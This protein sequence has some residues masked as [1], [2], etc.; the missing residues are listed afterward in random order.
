V[1]CAPAQLRLRVPHL[2]LMP[3][4]GCACSTLCS[5]PTQVA[6]AP[7]CAHAQLRLRV[8]HLVL[9]PNSG[10]AC[11]T[12]CSCPTQVAR[13]PPCAHALRLLLLQPCWSPDLLLQPAY[14][15]DLLIPS[16][17]P[18]LNLPLQPAYALDLLI[19][20]AP[21]P[22]L[23]MSPPAPALI[24]TSACRHLG[25]QPAHVQ[26]P[27]G[28]PCRQV[29]PGEPVLHAALRAAG[30]HQGQAAGRSLFPSKRS[31]SRAPVRPAS[32]LVGGHP[33]QAAESVAP[34]VGN[35]PCAAVLS[36]FLSCGQSPKPGQ[37]T[38]LL[39]PVIWVVSCAGP[40]RPA[41]PPLPGQHL[42][43][44][45][46]VCMCLCVFMRMCARVFRKAP[47]SILLS[48]GSTHLA[49]PVSGMQAGPALSSFGY[50]TGQP[51][52]DARTEQLV[53]EPMYAA[54]SRLLL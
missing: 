29:P 32:C 34:C 30:S 40:H 16:T 25:P 54:I 48:Q 46:W 42:L 51:Q 5:C 24:R 44:H 12:L 7:P 27:P 18:C 52:A 33:R 22:N 23:P 37:G 28:H 49:F 8:L 17:C 2:V 1:F 47:L 9:M 26:G 3:N 4:S 45:T 36:S 13:A 21:A 53:R 19:Q 50:N 43:L 38:L 14:A 10:C 39:L 11:P 20:P 6:R 15:L 41:C 35:R 31:R